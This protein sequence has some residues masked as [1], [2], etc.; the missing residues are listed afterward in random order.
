M[1]LQNGAD[2]KRCESVDSERCNVNAVEKAA[3][4]I[5][6]VDVVKVLIQNGDECCESVDSLRSY[7]DMLTLKSVVENGADVNAVERL[8][9]T[10]LFTA[11]S[12][13]MLTL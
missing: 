3:L 6:A 4:H 12:M 13:D 10:S 5:A 1:D 7:V 9:G 2:V 11:S 8:D